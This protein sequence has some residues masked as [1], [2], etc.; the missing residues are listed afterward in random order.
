MN[1]P[2]LAGKLCI[3]YMVYSSAYGPGT[4]KGRLHILYKCT[5]V[6]LLSK[7]LSTTASS[8][9]CAEGLH[10]SALNSAVNN[11]QLLKIKEQVR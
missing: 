4:N 8:T 5:I 1:Y 9:S 10:F 3:L 2:T 7:L 6:C 11:L